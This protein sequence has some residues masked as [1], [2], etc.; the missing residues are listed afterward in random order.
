[1][2]YWIHEQTGRLLYPTDI[3]VRM[4]DGEPA[5]VTGW[6]CDTLIAA[7][8]V[9]LARTSESSL[10]SVE[11][12]SSIDRMDLRALQSDGPVRRFPGATFCD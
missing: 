7:P 9:A 12:L 3:V 4:A 8:A 1:V 2:R 10:A 5:A 11:L 6:W